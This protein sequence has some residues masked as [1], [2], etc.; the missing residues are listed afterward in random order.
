VDVNRIVLRRPE[1][2]GREATVIVTFDAQKRA[3]VLV[4]RTTDPTAVEAP[5]L[6]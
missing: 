1:G 2:E 4:F 6:R 3:R 5:T